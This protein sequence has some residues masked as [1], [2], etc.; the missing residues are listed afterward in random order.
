VLFVP[1]C[2]YFSEFQKPAL[3]ADISAGADIPA[4]ILRHFVGTGLLKFQ[5]PTLNS[6][7]FKCLTERFANLSVVESRLP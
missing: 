6:S 2:G 4:K 1:F 7:I 3:S 5:I